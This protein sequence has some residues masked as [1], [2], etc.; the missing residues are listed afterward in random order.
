MAAKILVVMSDLFFSVKI[1]DAA[2]KF[3]TSIAVVKDQALAVERAKDGPPL[4]VLDLNCAG[5]DAAGLIT[6]LKA[7]SA[8]A[9]IPIVGFVSHVQIELRQRAVELGCD[10]VVPRSVFATSVEEIFAR[11]L[12]LLK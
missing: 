3:G 8:T 5:V 6:E 10:V 9:G 2:K 7:D 4:I 1:N 12:T 11:Y